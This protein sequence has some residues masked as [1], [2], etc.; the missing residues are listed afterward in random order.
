MIR[1][2]RPDALWSTYPIATAHK[3][4]HTLHRLTG[5]PWIADFRDP[6]A[7]DGFPADPKTWQ[8]F[9]KIEELALRSASFGVFVT[10]GS[11]RMYRERYPD[12]PIARLAV[13][14][15]GYDEEDFALL[16]A[17]ASQEGPLLPG[18]FTLLH[19]GIVYPSE[20]DPTRLFQALRHMIDTGTL[21]QGELRV[22]LRAPNFE[23]PLRTLIDAYRLTE[24]V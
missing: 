6:M 22:R 5:L 2:Y 11:A 18:T 8:S 4:G 13:I 19:S 15:N 9:R 21:R 17:A 16:D 20:R 14:E 23:A 24:I 10:P 12:I 1:K 7:Q 3:I